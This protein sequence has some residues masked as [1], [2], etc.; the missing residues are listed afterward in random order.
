MCS[1]LEYQQ[2]LF[3]YENG[4]GAI[5]LPLRSSEVGL[6]HSRAV[7]PV[8]LRRMGHWVTLALGQPFAYHNPFEFSTK[9]EM[10]VDVIRDSLYPVIAETVSC[11]RRRRAR[12]MQC[13]CCSSCLLRRQA[14][15]ANG[16]V[17][18]RSTYQVTS[19]AALG[20]QA[21]LR[22]VSHLAPMRAQVAE[23]EADIASYAPWT[24]LQRR[25]P[26]LADTAEEIVREDQGNL[27]DVHGQL[28]CLYRAYC[29]EWA[30]AWP[31]MRPR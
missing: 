2:E 23:M 20:E 11:D 9:A 17:E 15:A 28:I 8:M 18:P 26:D 21:E 25:Y 27:L 7:H 30:A 3:I 24:A 29:A 5:N 12:P 13:G 16:Y 22:R 10:C 1:A 14:L 31:L 4:V 6:D 19:N